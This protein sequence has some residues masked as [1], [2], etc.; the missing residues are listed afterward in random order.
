[1]LEVHR[2]ALSAFMIQHKTRQI[3]KWKNPVSGSLLRDLIF[4]AAY[5]LQLEEFKKTKLT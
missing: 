2:A 5:K 3:K 1:M 4:K